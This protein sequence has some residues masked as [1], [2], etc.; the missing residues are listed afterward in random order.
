MSIFLR[1]LAVAAGVFLLTWVFFRVALT[2]EVTAIESA[3]GQD[4]G[5]FVH[6]MDGAATRIR[7][8][9]LPLGALGAGVAVGTFGRNW[10][11]A[12]LIALFG[13]VPVLAL[14]VISFLAGPSF[15]T[16]T[17]SVLGIVLIFSSATAIMWWREQRHTN[18]A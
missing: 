2:A 12:W 14:L 17:T 8:V 4:V 11:W 15:L 6:T 3:R 16:A 7:F 10:H 13:G 1:N 9:Y 5:V 18:D